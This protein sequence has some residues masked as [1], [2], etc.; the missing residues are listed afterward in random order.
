MDP[1]YTSSNV[2]FL[3]VGVTFA[4]LADTDG[5]RFEIALSCAKTL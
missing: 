1:K 3:D 5:G 2:T 4:G